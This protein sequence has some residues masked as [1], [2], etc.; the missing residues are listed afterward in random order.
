MDEEE[1]LKCAQ[2]KN[3][4]RMTSYLRMLVHG[5]FSDQHFS[6]VPEYPTEE[7]LKLGHHLLQTAGQSR[8]RTVKSHQKYVGCAY[9]ILQNFYHFLQQLVH[10]VVRVSEPWNILS[11]NLWRSTKHYLN[12][13]LGYRRR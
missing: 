13:Y 12:P 1:T 9:I 11:L 7:S 8:V 6:I 3:I 10:L 5:P 2:D 4:I